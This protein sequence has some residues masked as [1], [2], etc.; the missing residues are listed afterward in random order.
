MDNSSEASTLQRH[1]IDCSENSAIVRESLKNI[2]HRL[3]KI[4]KTLIA[5]GESRKEIYTKLDV[6]NSR[7]VALETNAIIVHRVLWGVGAGVGFLI[8]RAILPYIS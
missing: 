6:S 4:D 5:Q 8:L 1:L 7:I 2:L 3:D